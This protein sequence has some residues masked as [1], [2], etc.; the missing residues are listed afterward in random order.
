MQLMAVEYAR[1]VLGLKTAN[2]T[3]IDPT[4]P[5]P[6]IYI[7]PD[8]KKNL[9]LRAYGGT[10]RL[11]KWDCVVKPGTLAHSIYKQ[12]QT[13]ERHRHRYEVNEAYVKRLADKGL[14]VSGR[15]VKENLVEIM[16]MLPKDHPFFLG[17]QGH[18]EYKSRPLSPHPIF[19]RFIDACA[20]QAE[21]VKS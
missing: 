17:T 11:G 21:S 4:T 19:L 2:S 8:Q 1:N 7:I 15:S 10:M 6:V 3:E 20:K 16:E 5:D 12:T 18:P 14:I 13:S 9:K